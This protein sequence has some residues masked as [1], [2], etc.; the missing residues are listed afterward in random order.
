M[1]TRARGRKKLNHEGQQRRPATPGRAPTTGCT[2]PGPLC[3]HQQVLFSGAFKPRR[4]P[5]ASEHCGCEKSLSPSTWIPQ[6]RRLLTFPDSLM[7][8]SPTPRL[9][10]FPQI[11][12]LIQKGTL[13]MQIQKNL[14]LKITKTALPEMPSP[15]QNFLCV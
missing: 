13:N 9:F 8:T 7:F 15:R 5:F 14:G 3:K 6:L 4:L 11:T 12:S 2:D 10:P 1:T